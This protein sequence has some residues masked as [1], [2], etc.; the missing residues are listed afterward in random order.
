MAIPTP[1]TE[2][3]LQNHLVVTKE[4]WLQ[5]RKELLVEEKIV[6]KQLD[7]ISR[8]RRALPWVRLDCDYRFEGP[9]GE[10]TL[11]FHSLLP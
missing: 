5:A 10:M 8:K 2:A 6:F 7:E 11:A 3:E 9:D 4:A 1:P